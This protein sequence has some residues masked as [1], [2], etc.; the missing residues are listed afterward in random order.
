MLNQIP[1]DIACDVKLNFS[2]SQVVLQCFFVLILILKGGF[3]GTFGV[4]MVHHVL[5]GIPCVLLYLNSR[6]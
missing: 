4:I 1:D 5:V 3:L 2:I 6:C